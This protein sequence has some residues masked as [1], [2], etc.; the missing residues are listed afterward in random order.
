MVRGSAAPSVPRLRRL[1]SSRL[2]S[3]T[4]WTADADDGEPWVQFDLG[5]PQVVVGAATQKRAAPRDDESVSAFD[6]LVYRETGS[7]GLDAPGGWFRVQD[8]AG[9]A[10]A[11]AADAVVNSCLAVPVRARFVRLQP[12]TWTAH[13]S[14]RAALLIERRCKDGPTI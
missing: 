5:T 3:T 14:L 2:G 1:G 13:T 4:G 9:P 10:C 6:L 11:D 8:L 7:A 12:T